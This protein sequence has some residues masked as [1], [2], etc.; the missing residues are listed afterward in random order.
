[1]DSDALTSIIVLVNTSL[2]TIYMEEI[3]GLNINII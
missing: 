2:S 1:M 3:K